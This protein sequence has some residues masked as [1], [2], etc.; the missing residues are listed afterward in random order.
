MNLDAQKMLFIL[1]RGR[2]GTTLISNVLNESQD[3]CIAP[4]GLFL[5]NLYRKYRYKKF[6]Y[7]TINLFCKDVYLEPKMNNWSFSNLELNKFLND[8]LS[9]DANFADVVK[10]VYSA[11][12]YYLGK[13]DIKYLGDKNPHYALFTKEILEV[14][15][16]AI[17]LHLIRDPRANVSSYKE[18]SFDYNDSSLLAYRWEKYNHDI[19]KSNVIN[20][21]YFVIKYEN[22]VIKPQETI[23]LISKNLDVNTFVAKIN[24]NNIKVFEHS[25][26][27]HKKLNDNFDNSRLEAWR[28]SLSTADIN[29]I[30]SI[31]KD[32]MIE[33]GYEGAVLLNSKRHTLSNVVSEATIFLEKFLFSVPLFLRTKVLSAYRQITRKKHKK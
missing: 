11:N 15:P 17:F 14:F 20:D 18:V 9:S 12:A 10:A 32:L 3:I 31:C 2:S 29:Y 24:S 25:K 7:N 22:L 4:E 33:Y 30:E 28:N 13:S 1:G 5:M 8:N 23:D 6:D 27:W 19:M 21:N 16:D 26:Q